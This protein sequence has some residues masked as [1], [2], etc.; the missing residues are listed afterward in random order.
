MITVTALACA[1]GFG[2]LDH[3][4]GP[5]IAFSP[6]YVVPI[7]LAAWFAGK[8]AGVLMAFFSA[9]TWLAADLFPP[10]YSHPAIVYWN[11]IARLSTFLLVALLLSH[12][13]SL[14]SGLKSTAEQRAVALATERN[15]HEA[16]R[17]ALRGSEERFR[18]LI[19]SV[20]DY[21]IF[22][23]DARGNVVTWHEGA[24]KLTGYP[25]DEILGKHFSRFWPSDEIDAG[26][27]AQ[28]LA[29][30]AAAGSCKHE[31]LRVRQD[32]SRFWAMGSLTAL[33]DGRGR[34]AG[35]SK[36]IHDITDRKRLENEVVEAEERERRRIGRD[37]HDVLGQ[38]LTGIAFLGKELEEDLAGRNA[39]ESSE[40]AR[41]VKLANQAVERARSLAQGL[42]PI[43]LRS[44]GLPTAL[45]QLAEEVT[46]VFGVQCDLLARDSPAMADDSVALHLYRIAQE[47]TSNA[48]KH[49]H[50]K[51]VTIS[52]TMEGNE[53]VLK[54]EDDGCGIADQ[55]PED[56]GMGL[57][58][59][60]YRATI[61]G[62]TLSVQRLR[63]HGTLITC[64]VPINQTNAEDDSEHGKAE[65][66]G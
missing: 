40:A 13:R 23:L 25:A 20:E 57:A 38:D 26:K 62:G 3:L 35:F 47:A 58:V 41:I 44:G 39:P 52:L 6:F 30:A 16:T 56:G 7:A 17:S 46:E 54:V 2:I 9:G 5:E 27:P 51:R 63:R 53:N 21:A 61:V 50:A 12:L 36:V 60:E 18:T 45:R 19:E 28:A 1:A 48:I 33:R 32:G 11:A 59:M 55:L 24:E 34:L 14:T 65:P 15:G 37:L 43:G 42:C 31:G 66:T 49:G 22:M 64:S 10:H 4:T 29:E 8:R